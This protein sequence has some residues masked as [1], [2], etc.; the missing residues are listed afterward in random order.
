MIEKKRCVSRRIFVYKQKT[1]TIFLRIIHGSQVLYGCYRNFDSERKRV[2]PHIDPGFE[3]TSFRYE[4]PLLSME[5]CLHSRGQIH[6]SNSGHFTTSENEWNR[7]NTT[8]LVFRG[9]CPL[10]SK[11]EDFKN[12]FQI[13]QFSCILLVPKHSLLKYFTLTFTRHKSSI[14]EGSGPPLMNFS[15]IGIKQFTKVF[16][17]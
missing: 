11:G 17:Y 5:L 13:F 7:R 10:K 14:L 15:S 1:F 9:L 4:N 12:G 16:P 6:H 8:K 3:P 2:W